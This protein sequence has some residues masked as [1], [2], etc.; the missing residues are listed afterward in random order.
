MN[1]SKQLKRKRDAEA[2][3][4]KASPTPV[5]V[6]SGGTPSSGGGTIEGDTY[7]SNQQIINNFTTLFNSPELMLD[8]GDATIRD[9]S[10]VIDGGGA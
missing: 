6:G 2:R 8:G 5:Y 10:L 9:F 7:I 1:I 4:Q 3:S